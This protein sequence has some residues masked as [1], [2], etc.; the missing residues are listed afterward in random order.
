M[1]KKMSVTDLKKHL[2]EK[3]QKELVDEL[4]S[5]YKRFSN[6]KDYYASILNPKNSL[7]VL[8]SYKEKVTTEFF[9]K[10]GYGTPKLSAIRKLINEYK[11]IAPSP[12]H[13]ID[14]LLHVVEQ[15]SA[16]TTEFGD[17]TESY[18]SSLE[19]TFESALKLMVAENS[20]EHFDERCRDIVKYAF[21]GWGFA[22]QLSYIY[23]ATITKVQN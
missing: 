8:A 23:D 15:G 3:S 14:L 1:V 4:T 9:P 5:L 10:R 13:T 17:M 6:V 22:D 19:K 21:Q 7:E 12:Q 2:K 16:F 18:Y 20:I 11:K